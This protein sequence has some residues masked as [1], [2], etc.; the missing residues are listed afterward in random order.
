[1]LD[2]QEEAA[3]LTTALLREA[4]GARVIW[5]FDGVVG[6]T[7]PLHEASYRELAERRSYGFAPD[8]FGDLVGHTE[9]WIW[10]RLISQGFPATMAEIEDLHAE[11]GAVVAAVALRS[12][13]PSWLAARVMPALDGV[14]DEQLV[15]SNGDPDLIAALL[16]GWNLDPFVEVARRT[17]G[18]DKEALFRSL[19]VP[20]CVVLEDSDTYL[21]L[22]RELGAFTV[23]VRHSHNPRA[24]LVADLTT[25]L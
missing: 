21:A 9:Q 10:E 20:P 16:A 24:A 7:E 14:A 15:V 23:G 18:R 1:M 11:R 4:A 17:P 6:H 5:D 2:D 22:G 12:L 13:E 3:A 8:F 19:C 25:H